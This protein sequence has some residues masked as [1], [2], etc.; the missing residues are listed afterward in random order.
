MRTLLTLAAA[1]LTA[2]ALAAVPAFAGTIFPPTQS[3]ASGEAAEW[4]GSWA[5]IAPWEGYFDYGDGAG[6]PWGPTNSTSLAFDH[7]FYSCTGETFGQGLL[8]T[9]ATGHSSFGTAS[10]F[11]GAGG[12]CR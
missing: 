10:T 12:L 11:V 5:G 2:L 8:A 3:R 9:D 7:A 6:R 4:T 1:A